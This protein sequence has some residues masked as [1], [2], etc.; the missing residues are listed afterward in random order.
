MKTNIFARIPRFAWVTLIVIALLGSSLA[1]EPVRA[2]AS[3]FLALFRVE[4]VRVIP[5]NEQAVSEQ[6]SNSSQLEYILSNEVDVEEMGESQKVL[7]AGEA[8]SLAGFPLRLPEGLQGDQS[9]MIQPGARLSFTVDLDL[10]EGVLKDIGR[11]DIQ[12]PENLDG[13]TI[14]VDVPT[15]VAASYG[16]CSFNEAEFKGQD[17][18]QPHPAS[19]SFENCVTL[20]QV[21]SPEISAPPDLDLNKIGEA[22]LQVLGMDPLE[23]ATFASTVN[24]T[25]TFVVPIPRNS[26]EYEE[27]QVGGSPATLVYDRD[28]YDRHYALI[29]IDD[30]IV[31]ALSGFGEKSDALEIA[32]S[33]Q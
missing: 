19:R 31:F 14:R 28:G 12:L 33:I 22:Y 10:V 32:N 4:Q 13:A 9:F 15:S 18:D 6:L 8:R 29:W 27:V 5:I 20:M 1:F 11:E 26:V 24:W 23:A 7:D 30:G 16:D 25:T 21:P 17:P 3:D 2:L